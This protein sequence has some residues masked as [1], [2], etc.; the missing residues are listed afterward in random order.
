MVDT[1]QHALNSKAQYSDREAYAAPRLIVFGA[2]GALTQSGSNLN[3]EFMND[4]CTPGMRQ[5]PMC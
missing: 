3:G 5:D 1:Q 4:M 2:V